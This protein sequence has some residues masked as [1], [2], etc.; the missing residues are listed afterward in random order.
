[1]ITVGIKQVN[2]L[3]FILECSTTPEFI[4]FVKDKDIQESDK[5]AF[6]VKYF[7]YIW[8]VKY[9]ESD[10]TYLFLQTKDLQDIMHFDITITFKGEQTN[11]LP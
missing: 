3:T 7:D 11:D 8:K 4:G 5:I 9:P 10:V 2:E 1:M 6:I